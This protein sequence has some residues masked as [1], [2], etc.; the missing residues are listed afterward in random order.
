MFNKLNKPLECNYKYISEFCQIIWKETKLNKF[1][2]K[3]ILNK[4]FNWKCQLFPCL[5]FLFIAFNTFQNVL[6]SASIGKIIWK[7]ENISLDFRIILYEHAV[8]YMWCSKDL[9]KN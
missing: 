4:W 2:W 9:L 7:M 6:E 5:M 8:I 1:N 3:N